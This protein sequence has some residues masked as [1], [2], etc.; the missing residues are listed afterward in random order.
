MTAFVQ[1]QSMKRHARLLAASVALAL[2]LAPTAA[3]AAS[4]SGQATTGLAITLEDTGAFAVDFSQSS[5]SLD[6]VVD[7]NPLESG[8][9]LGTVTLRIID[10]HA[11]RGQFSI[12][13]A[14]ADFVSGTPIRYANAIA[15]YAIPAN[16]LTLI[17]ILQPIEE[18]CSCDV[19]GYSYP[20]GDVYAVSQ[21]GTWGDRSYN[22]IAANT[23]DQK[24]LVAQGLA[25]SGTILTTQDLDLHLSVPASL[26]AGVYRSTLTATYNLDTP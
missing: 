26:P 3:T 12:R 7:S 17:K 25:G 19:P 23:L 14:A 15:Y 2:F 24:R 22:W 18:R 1:T 13:I 10:T 9:A 21:D 6:G 16:K 8:A 11:Y 20:V 5:F 4:V